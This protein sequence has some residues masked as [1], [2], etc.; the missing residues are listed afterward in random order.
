MTPSHF[1]WLAN[2]AST[3]PPS[4]SPS[5]RRHLGAP[6]QP[7]G[8]RTRPHRLLHARPPPLLRHTTVLQGSRQPRLRRGHRVPHVRLLHPFP[9][10]TFR[11]PDAPPRPHVPHQ[12]SPPTPASSW[13]ACAHLRRPQPRRRPQAPARRPA[14]HPRLDR[15]A[16]SLV[17]GRQTST[18][19]APLAYE[20]IRGRT[21]LRRADAAD[22]HQR[23]H[24]VHDDERGVYPAA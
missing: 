13:T 16:C 20:P 10:A 11:S 6:L 19:P 8:R 15:S 23:L 17:Q 24:N 18:S 2:A 5:D 22:H 1:L 12:T 4:R 14:G 3:R 21:L 7:R 9:S